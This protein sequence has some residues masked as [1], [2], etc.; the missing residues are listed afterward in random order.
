MAECK[1]CFNGCTISTYDKCIKYTGEDVDSLEIC[2]NDGLDEV[3]EKIIENLEGYS[4]GEGITVTLSPTPCTLISDKLSANYSLS[5]I[6]NAYASAICEV[7]EEL[8]DVITD[9]GNTYPFNTLCLTLGASPTKDDI[10]QATITQTCANT[11]SINTILNDYVKASELNTL[12]QQY[13]DEISQTPSGV[14]QQ[15]TKMVPYVAYEYYGSLANFDSSGKGL[16]NAGFEKVYLCNGSN[17]TPDKRGRVAVGVNVGIPGGAM[18]S[19]V[20]PSVAGNYQVTLKN[21]LGEFK[22]LNTV[23]E[24]AAHVHSTSS[25]NINVPVKGQYGGDNDDHNNKTAFAAG[26]KG[27]DTPS[28]FTL[29]SVVTI[30]A[31]AT[32]SQ[33]ASQP[34]NVTQPSIGALYI[35]YIP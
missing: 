24:M 19:K 14:I 17:G 29:S 27:L 33:G 12:I 4:T 7:K 8:D 35:M 2:N 15:N 9:I 5:S 21:K 25:T 30:P 10:L 11:T 22:H 20:D 3:I 32:N 34:S 6:L 1:N 13:L 16:T 23:A 28:Y 26:D 31:L 18:D